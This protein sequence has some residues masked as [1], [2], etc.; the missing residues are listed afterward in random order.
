MHELSIN[1]Q[2]GQKETPHS[3][4]LNLKKQKIRS[5]DKWLINTPFIRSLKM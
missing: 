3:F 2:P 1:H 5:A 4:I